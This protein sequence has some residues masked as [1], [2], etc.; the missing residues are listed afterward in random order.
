MENMICNRCENME[1]A[2]IPYINKPVYIKGYCWSKR[3]DGWVV[4]YLNEQEERNWLGILNLY[5]DY[6][7][8]TY[9]VYGFL[10]SRHDTWT[11]ATYNNAIY[12]DCVE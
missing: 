9:P 7:G 8:K 6:K 2:L 4:L 1:D 5:F 3:F 10:P 12:K 11:S